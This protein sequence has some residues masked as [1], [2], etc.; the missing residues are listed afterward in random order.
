[1]TVI[2]YRICLTGG[3][4]VNNA[5]VSSIQDLAKSFSNYHD[6]VLVC[7]PVVWCKLIRL[8]YHVILGAKC[9][10]Y[11]PVVMY[12]VFYFSWRKNGVFYFPVFNI[13]FCINWLF[14]S[15]V[16]QYSCIC[17][18]VGET[19]RATSVYAKCHFRSKEEC[20]HCEVITILLICSWSLI[21]HAC[22]S[23]DRPAW[24]NVSKVC[25]RE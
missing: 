12:L 16:K 9:S 23:K 14:L 10:N 22:V 18:H 11:S 2:C 15:F 19:W 4:E 8:N 7:L 25:T 20:W 1:M 5:I 21:F 17:I 24:Y 13:K 6:E 3:K